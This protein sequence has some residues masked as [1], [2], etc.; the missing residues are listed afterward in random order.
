MDTEEL[1][2]VIQT[3]FLSHFSYSPL[4]GMFYERT[5]NDRI[6]YIH[7]RALRFAYKDYRTDFELLRNQFTELILSYLEIW[8]FLQ[9]RVLYLE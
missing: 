8:I 6:N 7:E 3:F 5:L 9:N 1:K 4:V 2:Q